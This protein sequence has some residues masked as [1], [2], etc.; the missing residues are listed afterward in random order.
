MYPSTGGKGKKRQKGAQRGERRTGGPRIG[1]PLP[2]GMSDSWYC[3]WMLRVRLRQEKSR[4][5][6]RQGVPWQGRLPWT[7]EVKEPR[8][9]GVPWAPRLSLAPDWPAF[10]TPRASVPLVLTGLLRRS[11]GSL[12]PKSKG[13][14]CQPG[15]HGQADPCQQMSPFPS[16]LLSSQ[17]DGVLVISVAEVVPK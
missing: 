12:L 16:E 10:F 17:P 11:N 6:Q 14:H 15:P 2:V 3:L 9:R 4:Q 1:C 8:S 7:S 5:G 13:P